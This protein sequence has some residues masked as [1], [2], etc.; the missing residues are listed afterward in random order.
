[1]PIEE[2]DV[3]D[4]A[5]SF[6]GSS[7]TR[8]HKS[9]YGIGCVVDIITGL[10]IHFVVLSVYCHGCACANARYGGTCTVTFLQ[11]KANHRDCNINYSGSSEGW[12]R[13]LLKYCGSVL[14]TT[15]ESD[16]RPCCLMGKPGHRSLQPERINP[17]K[18]RIANC[19]CTDLRKLSTESKKRGVTLGGRG[20]GKLT[21]P[22][23]TQAKI[24]KCD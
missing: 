19:L 16:T 7:M 3:I 2:D 1:M 5:V 12:R 4:L 15:F 22:E 18:E 11:W 9:L 21:Q 20:K 24:H 17:N 8:G 10:V 23:K 14:S 6:D 13:K